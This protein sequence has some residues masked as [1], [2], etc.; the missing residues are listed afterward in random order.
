MGNRVARLAH[1]TELHDAVFAV[2]ARHTRTGLPLGATAAD[3]AAL[4]RL[5]REELQARHLGLPPGADKANLA[6]AARQILTP[7][8]AT[9]L[10]AG[11]AP[12]A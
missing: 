9:Q 2:A 10:A 4:Y 7:G 8:Y 5:V 6:A 3:E 12:R 11:A 1:R